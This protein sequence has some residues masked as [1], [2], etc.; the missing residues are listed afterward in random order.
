[1]HKCSCQTILL[2]LTYGTTGVTATLLCSHVVDLAP[3]AGSHAKRQAATG[4]EEEVLQL[5]QEYLPPED[6]Q[7]LQQQ[8]Q[9]QDYRPVDTGEHLRTHIADV[10]IQKACIGVGRVAEISTVAACSSDPCHRLLRPKRWRV[11]SSK[12]L[13]GPCMLPLAGSYISALCAAACLQ[14]L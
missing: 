6:R 8:Q 12:C 11:P 3:T 4:H 5:V 1:M 13:S 10:V 7:M 14:T 2:H 9:Q